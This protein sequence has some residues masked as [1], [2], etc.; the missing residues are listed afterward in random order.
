M[1]T[2]TQWLERY[3]E[4]Y[5]LNFIC[6][7]N[8]FLISEVLSMELRARKLKD[9][10]ILNCGELSLGEIKAELNQFSTGDKRLVVLKGVT[11]KLL[12]EGFIDD[13]CNSRFMRHT[14]IIVVYHGEVNT[15]DK[16]I[17]HFIEKGRYVCC[18]KLDIEKYLKIKKFDA[19]TIDYLLELFG[20]SSINDIINTVKISEYL[21]DKSLDTLKNLNLSSSSN[22][23][24]FLFDK[25]TSIPELL[26]SAC[27]I[28]KDNFTRLIGLIEYHLSNMLFIIK[29]R[30]YGDKTNSIQI[31]DK[32]G[33][34]PYMLK[35][36]FKWARGLNTQDIIKR[37][38]LLTILDMS[39]HQTG[40]IE[41]FVI[42]WQG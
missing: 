31:A 18:N 20:T 14:S 9:K 39:K 19:K 40:A 29:Y 12:E 4:D 15:K 24:N 10:S 33:I 5:R 34:H 32:T 6:G 11:G 1:A 22:F 17:R 2:F 26:K 38:K 7:T 41:R 37:F 23:V 36:Y 8:D 21:D 35:F 28:D 42:A 25:T 3:P 16:V 27:L 30:T 13:F